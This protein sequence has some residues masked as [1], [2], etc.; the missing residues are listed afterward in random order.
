MNLLDFSLELIKASSPVLVAM[1]A[2]LNV[3]MTIR[4]RKVE[5]SVN[6]MKSE[7]VAATAKGSYLEGAKDATDKVPEAVITL[8]AEVAKDVLATAEAKAQKI[9]EP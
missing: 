5:H 1:I 9:Q 3:W 7:L 4:L 8:A 2:S 6:G